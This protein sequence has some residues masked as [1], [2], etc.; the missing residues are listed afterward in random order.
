MP[1]TA[2]DLDRRVTFQRATTVDNEYNEPVETWQDLVSVPAKR[3]DLS[4][5]QRLEFLAA[6][7][8]GAFTIVRFTVRSSSITRTITPVDR[9]THEGAIW[10][11]HSIKELDEGRRRFL[12]VTA[13][14]DVS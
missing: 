10:E 14:R 7:Q 6:G 3:Q 11:I 4:D 2:N 9:L 5:R 1:V 12:E 13:R 8:V